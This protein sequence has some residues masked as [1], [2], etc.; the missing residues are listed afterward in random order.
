MQILHDEFDFDDVKLK[1]FA[2]RVDGNLDAINA[3]YVTFKDIV[4]NLSIKEG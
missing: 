3:D 1:R 4:E 2:E